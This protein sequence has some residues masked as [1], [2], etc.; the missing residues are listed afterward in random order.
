M[1]YRSVRLAQHAALGSTR[2]YGALEQEP[3][4]EA[5][6]CFRYLEPLLELA[7]NRTIIAEFS[8][9]LVGAQPV[10]A[11]GEVHRGHVHDVLP[12]TAGDRDAYQVPTWV[13]EKGRES[14]GEPSAEANVK[15]SLAAVT[16]TPLSANSIL[17][18]EPVDLPGHPLDVRRPLMSG[19]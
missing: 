6:V 7:G 4:R 5:G 11:V 2:A 16:S 14:V 18:G 1:V 9:V 3:P 10:G 12:G 17:K 8:P 19:R 15:I 13:D